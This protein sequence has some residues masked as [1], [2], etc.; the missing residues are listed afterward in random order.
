[1]QEKE[2]KYQY[3]HLLVSQ[4]SVVMGGLCVTLFIHGYTSELITLRP[5]LLPFA[6]LVGLALILG[7]FWEMRQQIKARPG[8]PI[9]DL[10]VLW[11]GLI[12]IL[13]AGLSVYFLDRGLS[14]IRVILLVSIT[15][16]L[17]VML[18]GILARFFIEKRGFWS[19]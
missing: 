11:G 10:T 15:V 19:S 12:I 1:M 9:S 17:L 4:F 2:K 6:G 8:S 3:R 5:E 7:Y 18:S 13:G 16:G 14:C